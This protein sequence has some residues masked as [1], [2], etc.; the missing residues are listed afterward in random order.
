MYVEDEDE[1]SFSEG[2][3]F[4]KWKWVRRKGGWIAG[5][6]EGLGQSFSINPHI[7]RVLIVLSAL[8]FGSGIIL[9]LVFAFILPHERSLV[10]YARPQLFGVCYRLSERSKIELPLMRV[11]MVLGILF[12]AGLFLLLYIGLGVYFAF[13]GKE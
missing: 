5:V 3:D 2:L 9:Y 12:S 8:L 7:L 13:Q 10:N 1:I 11:F 6:F 4:E